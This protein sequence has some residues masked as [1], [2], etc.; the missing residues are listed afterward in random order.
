MNNLL[1]KINIIKPKCFNETSG[2]ITV[3]DLSG[4]ILSFT[5]PD[6]TKEAV[7]EDYGRSISNL[8]C[9][10]YIVKIYNIIKHNEEKITLDL[11]CAD[12]LSIDL[13]HV[14]EAKCYNNVINMLI[15]W[16]GGVPP[17]RLYI[18]NHKL[19]LSENF[20]VYKITPNSNYNIAVVDNNGCIAKKSNIKLELHPLRANIKWDPILKYNEKCANVSCDITGGKPPYKTAWFADGDSKPI[21]VNQYSINNL[22]KA[23]TYQLT[24][25]DSNN[26]QITDTFTISEPQPIAVSV[27]SFNDYSTKSLY[28]PSETELVYNLLLIPSD[29]PICNNILNT[30]NIS[31]KYDKINVEQRLCMDYGNIKI[32][33]EIYNY[34][35]ISPGIPNH[36]IVKSNLIIDD[37][38]CELQHKFG[39]RKAKLVKG[40]LLIRDD[41]SFSFHNNDIITIKSK[42]N[43]INTQIDQVYIKTGLYISNSIYTILNMINPNLPNYDSLLFINQEDKFIVQS[44][45][46]KSNY[47]L[48]SIMCTA[49]NGDRASLQAILT[50]SEGESTEY[51]FNN[52]YTLTI[53]N[54][55]YGEYKLVIKDNYSIASIFNNKNTTNNSFTV[56][57]LDSFEKEREISTMVSANI[58][59]LD[60]SILNTYDVRPNKLLFY[61]PEFQNGVLM[62]ISPLDC[63]YSII[64]QDIQIEDCGYKV[65]N[66]LPHGKYKIK[67]FKEGYKT[68]NIKLFYN[69]SKELVT[70]ILQKE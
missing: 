42:D 50:N 20:Y 41:N 11:S 17:Y 65:I 31:I 9:G 49:F 35:Y 38:S 53:D 6:L 24:V 67:I 51:T 46:S 21:I 57:I 16:S 14:D 55:K 3:T 37:Q 48:G 33:D 4:G 2:S 29:N 54:L 64:G 7:V 43:F 70:V 60:P 69:T 13:V 52:K 44:L 30:S 66:N 27:L 22:L 39:N 10:K 61:D 5:W 58:F 47:R 36:K 15:E 26:C 32:D 19:T 25:T 1:Y 56:N 23:G 40:S 18:N 59:N 68:E 45:T 12:E 63:C 62:N 8:S 34:Y 28:D